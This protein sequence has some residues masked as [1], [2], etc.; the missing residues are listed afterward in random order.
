MPTKN[1]LKNR[2]PI[3]RQGAERYLEITLLSFA[4]SVSVTR[5]FLQL[6]GYPKIGSGE[7]HI[8][9]VLWGGLLLFIAS[10]IML[11]YANRWVYLLGSMISGIGVG[12]FIDEV[13]KFITQNNDYFYPS[14]AP[15]IYAFFLL[16]FLVFIIIRKYD[17]KKPDARTLFYYILEDMNEVLDHDLS[18]NEKTVIIKRLDMV[19][20]QS[21]HP[22]LNHLAESIKTFITNDHPYL[23]EEMPYFYERIWIRSREWEN[24]WMTRRK[25]K[26]AILVSLL[27]LAARMVF[28]PMLVISLI[29][30]PTELSKIMM[31]LADE[32]V[33][34]AA[35]GLTWLQ[36]R[37][38]LEG[39]LGVVL[40]IS[41]ILIV[42]RKE[43]TGILLGYLA[44][45]FTLTIVNLV[46]FYFNQFSTIIL[47]FFQFFV[48]LLMVR[49][50]N[51][52]MNQK[53]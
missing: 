35:G 33:V 1:P 11:I 39:S 27:V 30:N 26:A 2:K 17:N 20:N 22:D 5:L 12:L 7:L 14:A 31:N 8:A 18:E 32:H 50:R 6:T 52:F 49:Y 43:K 48:L 15:I 21:L 34:N 51:K 9:H 44:L 29:Q 23:V 47:A 38:G 41:A 3:R 28:Y 40:F 4:V 36:A 24:K 25:L 13:G 16:T 37:I 10:L 45:I 46:V 42:S 19:I 53:I